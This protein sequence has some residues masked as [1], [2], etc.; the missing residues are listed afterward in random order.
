MSPESI[1]LKK[2]ALLLAVLGLV[3]S[4]AGWS[5]SRDAASPHKFTYNDVSGLRIGGD[6]HLTDHSGKPR[7]LVDF[8]GKVV[9]VYFGYT[10][11]AD[12][13]PITLA[14]LAQAVKQLGALGDRVQVLFITV[15]PRRDTQQVLAQYLAAFDP[16]FLGLRGDP[17]TTAKIAA[18]YKADFIMPPHTGGSGHYDVGHTEGIFLI[19]RKGRTRLFVGGGRTVDGLVHDIRLLLE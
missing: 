1:R 9:G 15:D 2:L 13:C 19:D 16:R 17:A 14:D 11:C 5:Q 18:A 6:F 12:V 7:S 8:R 4:S 3:T 10:H